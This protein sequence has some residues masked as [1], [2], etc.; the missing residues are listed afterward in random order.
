MINEKE[1]P[2]MLRSALILAL[3]TACLSCAPTLKR[4]NVLDHG[5]VACGTDRDV[6]EGVDLNENAKACTVYIRLSAPASCQAKLQKYLGVGQVP[7]PADPDPAD[8]TVL[9]TKPVSKLNVSCVGNV[10]GAK[11]G[12]DIIKVVCDENPGGVED[13]PSSNQAT[14]VPLTCGPNEVVLWTGPPGKSCKVT[15]RGASSDDC[16]LLLRGEP[17]GRNLATIPLGKIQLVTVVDSP[18]VIAKCDGN[19][20]GQTCWAAVVSTECPP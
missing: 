9:I 19:A 17:G 11:C 6:W 5:E 18:S 10:E 8:T 3:A 12:Y 7:A 20:A 15:V 4:I 14:R 2:S 16:E 1:E 13:K